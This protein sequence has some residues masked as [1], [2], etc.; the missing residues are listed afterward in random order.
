[1]AQS[2]TGRF[3]RKATGEW[4]NL[5]WSGAPAGLN[6]YTYGRLIPR[7]VRVFW[8]NGG[9]CRQ[10]YKTKENNISTADLAHAGEQED[11]PAVTQASE[12]GSGGHGS[13]AAT[14]VVPARS[15]AQVTPLFP[16]SEAGGFRSRWENIQV[17]F[18]DEP[19][20]SVQQADQLVAEVIKRLA[21]QFATERQKLEEQ[22]GRSD[23]VSTEDLRSLFLNAF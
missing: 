9:T 15:L 21:E 22:W 11:L 4:P 8:R 16:S 18:V 14:A 10:D 2:T 5:T 7:S 20:G 6:G 13:G 17:G 3:P 19:R 12:H 23:H 1:M